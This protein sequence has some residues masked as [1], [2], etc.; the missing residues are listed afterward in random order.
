[1]SRLLVEVIF[2]KIEAWPKVLSRRSS[3]V[4]LFVKVLLTV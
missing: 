1:L 2:K 4:N 3:F